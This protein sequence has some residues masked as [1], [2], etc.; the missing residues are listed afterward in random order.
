MSCPAAREELRRSTR[1]GV[2]SDNI[3]LGYCV[4]TA[5]VRCVEI[6]PR[7][8]LGT[9]LVSGFPLSDNFGTKA[10]YTAISRTHHLGF[11]QL[12]SRTVQTL[13][14]PGRLQRIE[15]EERMSQRNGQKGA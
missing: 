4:S 7:E 11:F 12:H 1:A 15:D 9:M 14:R 6:A 3:F 10:D 5:R 13:H 8:V 2:S